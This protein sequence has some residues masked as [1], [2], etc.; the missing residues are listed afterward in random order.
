[1]DQLPNI[2]TCALAL[3]TGCEDWLV[4]PNK[5]ERDHLNIE[6]LSTIVSAL[7]VIMPTHY[8]VHEYM[9]CDTNKL[10]KHMCANIKKD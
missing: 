4:Q 8:L 7:F 6:N 5:T 3:I 10:K 2:K 9:R 1:M